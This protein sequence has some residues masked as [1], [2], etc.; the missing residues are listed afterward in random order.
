MNSKERVSKALRLEVPDRIPY[1]EFSIDFD[2]AEKILGHETYL[3]AKAKS[4]IAFWE[5]RRDEVVQS[6]K[7]DTVELY[8]KL[9]CVDIVNVSSMASSLVPPRDYRPNPPKRLDETTWIDEKGRVYKLSDITHDITMI[10]DPGIWEQEFNIEDYPE[11]VP[12]EEPDESIFEVVDYV[13]EKL[14]KEKFILGPSGGEV[15]MVL[16]GGMERGLTEYISNPEVVKA[17]ARNRM[18]KANKN[19]FHY[20]RKGTDGVFWG[21]D[22]AYKSGPMISPAMFRE[23]VFPILKE[24]IQKVNENFKL[25]VLKH[26]CGNNWKLMDMLV[27]AGFSCYQS[28]QGTAGMDIREVKE[29]YGDKICLWGG[30][31]VENLVGGTKEDIIKDVRYAVEHAAKNGGFILGATHSIAVGCNYDNYMTMLDEFDK[32]KYCY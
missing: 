31:S 6:W 22:F 5:G 19:D 24:R 28:I 30:V 23:F 17:A 16:L 8:K 21:Q 27:E 14:G 4:Q 26:A 32:L 11:D 2:T 29:K 18:K 13:I 10:E 9:D 1:G 12:D 7:E 3:R 20:I 15:G 25:P